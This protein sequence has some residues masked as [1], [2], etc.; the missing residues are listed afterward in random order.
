MRI[1]PLYPLD[2]NRAYFTNQVGQ[3]AF[4]DWNRFFVE[5]GI[6]ARFEPPGARPPVALVLAGVALLLALALNELRCRR[7]DLPRAAFP[8]ATEPQA[9]EGA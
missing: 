4:S 2:E 7:L 3:K 8:R 1:V 6:T 9:R 5:G